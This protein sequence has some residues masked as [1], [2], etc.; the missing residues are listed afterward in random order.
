MFSVVHERDGYPVYLPNDLTAFVAGGD[1]LGAWV[2]CV[3]ASIVGHVA[4]HSRSWGGVMRVVRE[5]L[6]CAE[7][8]IAVVA[9]L[10]VAPS[11]R[12]R[13][14]G[15]ALL[16]RAAHASITLGR[17]PVLD[18]AAHYEDAIRLYDAAGWSPVGTVSFPLPNGTAVDE[19]VFAG[20]EQL[21]GDPL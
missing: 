17:R 15:R 13:G 19:V 10:A 18:V 20:P 16:T 3:G 21:E 12:R 4:L 9:R 6:C 2:A 8:E 14:V 5:V 11:A 1:E 7:E